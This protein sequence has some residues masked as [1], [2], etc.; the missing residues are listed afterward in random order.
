[1]KIHKIEIENF[2]LFEKVEFKFD[3][4]FNLLIGINGSGKTSLLRAIAVS[5]GGWANAYIKSDSNLRPIKDSEIR[6]IQV[7]GR[8]DKT[9]KVAIRTGGT[10]TIINRYGYETNAKAVWSRVRDENKDTSLFGYIQYQNRGT[11]TYSQEYILNFSTLGTDILRYIEKG[12]TFDLPLIAFYECDR[13]WLA[14]NELNIE[15]SAKAQYSRFDPYVD[16]FHTGADHNAIGEWLLK[17]ELASLQQGQD[18]PV[19]L[20]I[21]NAVIHSL[22]N[23]TDISFDFEEGRVIVDF[24]DDISIPF[25]HLSDGQRTILGLFCDIARRAAI[26]NPHFGGEASEKTKGVILIDELDLHLHPKWQMK[27]VEDLRKVFP[28]IQFICT[29]HSPIL[30]RSIEKE[31]IIILENGEQSKNE[32]FSKGRDINSILYDF[33]GVPKRTKEY[34]DKV[35]NLFG[36]IDDDNIEQAELILQDL[37]KDYGEKDSVVIEAQTMID[38]LKQL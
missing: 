29:T 30:L 25:E 22:E 2:K 14:K 21:K 20:S 7:D 38:V 34:E 27:I 37:K 15:A 26:L 35:D 23:C 19:L 18:T 10:A 16:C 5:L 32:Y 24:E 31:K 36:F 12:N 28:N 6:E 4:N 8:F 17:H 3:D 33:M 11:G 1:M 13:L 9:K